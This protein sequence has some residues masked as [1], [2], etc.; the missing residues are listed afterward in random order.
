MHKYDAHTHNGI[1]DDETNG[2]IGTSAVIRLFDR[3]NTWKAFVSVLALCLII[4]S[5]LY[6]LG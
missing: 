1:P 2:G 4:N 3:I 6:S 5:L